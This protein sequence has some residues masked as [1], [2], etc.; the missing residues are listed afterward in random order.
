MADYS[1]YKSCTFSSSWNYYSGGWA[2]KSSGSA[3]AGRSGST[4]YATYHYF[5]TPNVT[6]TGTCEVIFNVYL[7]EVTNLSSGYLY[8]AVDTASN[9]T[10]GSDYS[11]V[12]S[13][14]EYG[15]IYVGD[16]GTDGSWKSF[17]AENL[18]PNTG[19]YLWIGG[20]K[21]DSSYRLMYHYPSST[22]ATFYYNGQT[23]PTA[24]TTVSFS[25][26]G[27]RAYTST[28]TLSWDGAINGLENAITGYK[29][30][31][32]TDGT[33]PT[34]SSPFV[35]TDET[36]HTFSAGFFERGKTIRCAVQTIGTVENLHSSLQESSN[37]IVINQLPSAPTVTMS[38]SKV[39]QAGGNVTF[40]V[41][42]GSDPEGQSRTIW[43]ALSS[44]G[45][46]TQIGNSVSGSINLTA[47]SSQKTFY[48][49]TKDSLG[50]YSSSTSKTIII[51]T[52]PRISSATATAGENLSGRF[53][54]GVT[55]ANTV[56]L[57][58]TAIDSNSDSLSYQWAYRVSN[59]ASFTGEWVSLST[60]SSYTF[61]LPTSGSFYQ[62]RITVNDGQDTTQTIVSS[63][64]QKPKQYFNITSLEA[65]NKD[66]GQNFE[67][68]ENTPYSEANS[69]SSTAGRFNNYIYL[70]WVS[71]TQ[72][73]GHLDYKTYFEYSINEGAT[74][75]TLS[76]GSF[77]TGTSLT[78]SQT[79]SGIERGTSFKFR[80]RF[81]TNSTS[82]SVYSNII[83]CVR[84]NNIEILEGNIYISPNDVLR[85]WTSFNDSNLSI[86]APRYSNNIEGVIWHIGLCSTNEFDINNI[87]FDISKE[88]PS[89]LTSNFSG[90]TATFEIPK[91]WLREKLLNNTQIS[92]TNA[93]WNFCFFCYLEDSFGNVTSTKILQNSFDYRETPSF[94]TGST[95]TIKE[96]HDNGNSYGE[97]TVGINS[98]EALQFTF[99]AACDWNN[100]D[101]SSVQQ[102]ET[103]DIKYYILEMSTSGEENANWTR[104]ASY[105][106]DNDSLG[107][108]KIYDYKF[109]SITK[110]ESVYFSVFAQDS[111]GL[112]SKRLIGKNPV[113]LY[114]AVSPTISISSISSEN[115][116]FVVKGI[117]TDKGGEYFSRENADKKIDKNQI[118]FNINY[119]TNVENLDQTGIFA[120]DNWDSI[121]ESEQNIFTFAFPPVDSG[122][123]ENVN[124]FKISMTIGYG[125]DSCYELI[126]NTA[127]SIYYPHK[128]TLSYRAS[129][130][131][132]NT[133]SF[134][135]DDVFVIKDTDSRYI[136]RLIGNTESGDTIVTFNLKTGEVAGAVIDGGTW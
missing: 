85:P 23:A 46:K 133:D 93:L 118:V 105:L 50:E 22:Y 31:Y 39:P 36:S 97:Y 60:T 75:G 130:L 2:S 10:W 88:S 92:S 91:E 63:I 47:S 45:E 120:Y 74:W 124:Y 32:T 125:V 103:S 136:I 28:N 111:L 55:L 69:L 24:P 84:I 110:N 101:T 100:S 109:D 78:S 67:T 70:S 34:T 26:S 18:E 20:R 86:E 80:L 11:P 6:K 4:P 52:P 57:N 44:S 21:A 132:I 73:E 41:T 48:F 61:N 58:C 43:Y 65:Y 25:E 3:Y 99:P 33:S 12:G 62:F 82:E 59:S 90:N 79:L 127:S 121:Y 81:T 30:Y 134:N 7:K 104:L 51:N 94:L 117:V 16:V 96:T 13:S 108:P 37:T 66:F 64:F 35:T 71:P 115:G 27:T 77:S 113:E 106:N 123:L 107:E 72:E 119:G 68:I 131:G 98:Q 83:D 114:R 112:T 1:D 8:W 40:T 5:T 9:A 17:T 95:L 15:R 87:I 135:T 14:G 116:Q 126:S 49:Y 38:I 122:L 53:A 42:A 89:D 129:H 29:I 102:I 76:E 19:Y 128:P 54:S 56:K